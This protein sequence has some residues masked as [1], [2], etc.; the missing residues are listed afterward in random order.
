MGS[1]SPVFKLYKCAMALITALLLLSSLSETFGHGAISYPIPW[2]NQVG[3]GL[4]L[5][6]IPDA[7]WSF[8]FEGPQ[9]P[10]PDEVC[11]D[12]DS[13]HCSGCS[14]IACA[15]D[16]YTN[17][18]FIPGHRQDLLQF[19]EKAAASMGVTP[20]DVNARSRARITTATERMRGPMAHA[21]AMMMGVVDIQ[22]SLTPRITQIKGYLMRQLSLFGH[23]ERMQ[24]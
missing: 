21:V 19:L 4:V 15:N 6:S 13:A 16:F 7:G 11:Q 17:Y 12:D 22:V 1:Y 18:T 3:N 14:K 10:R 20:M 24:K 5:D 23:G 9:W 2:L 8:Y